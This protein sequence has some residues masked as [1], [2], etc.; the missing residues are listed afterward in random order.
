[1][2][3]FTQPNLV[4][5]TLKLPFGISSQGEKMRSNSLVGFFNKKRLPIM[6][7]RV[8]AYLASA[9]S[10]LPKTG[11]TCLLLSLWKVA[12]RS[13]ANGPWTFA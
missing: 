8:R 1:M 10:Y 6:L 4:G 5:S 13:F 12:K 11:F 2:E 9:T 7:I 3:I